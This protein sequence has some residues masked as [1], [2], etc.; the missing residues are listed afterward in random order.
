[1]TIVGGACKAQVSARIMRKN[2]KT[3]FAQIGHLTNSN[4]SFRLSSNDG[5]HTACNKL[6]LSAAAYESCSSISLLIHEY[7]AKKSAEK[8]RAHSFPWVI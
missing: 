4:F 3:K 7:E 2:R 5:V 8:S 6:C 1:M